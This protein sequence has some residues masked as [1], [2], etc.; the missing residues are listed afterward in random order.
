[1]NAERHIRTLAANQHAL[2]TGAQL[3]ALGLTSGQIERRTRRGEL[4]RLHRGVYRIAGSGPPLEQ[5][6]L[7]ACLAVGGTVAASHRCGAAIWQVDLPGATPIEASVPV[8]RRARL[9]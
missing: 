3:R 8:G 4:D 2:V 1:M 7:A 6:S 5:A 9:A